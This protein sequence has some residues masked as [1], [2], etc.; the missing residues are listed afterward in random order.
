MSGLSTDETLRLDQRLSALSRWENE[1]GATTLPAEDHELLGDSPPLTATEILQL[2]VRV[3][4]LE[5]LVLAL[6]AESKDETHAL[7]QELAS[8]ISPRPGFTA[9]PMTLRAAAQMLMLRERAERFR[10]R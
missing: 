2:R 6:L 4:A 9:H 10:R 8:C 5:N 3:I 1:G 7:V